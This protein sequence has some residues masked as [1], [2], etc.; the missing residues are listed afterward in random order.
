MVRRM[1]TEMEL[2]LSD[3]DEDVRYNGTRWTYMY[4]VGTF[5]LYEGLQQS[6]ELF[7]SFSINRYNR[8]TQIHTVSL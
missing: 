1:I 8:V 5:D 2:L 4:N 6:A 3:S 7:V